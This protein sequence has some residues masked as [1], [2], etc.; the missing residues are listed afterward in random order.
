MMRI[1]RV[2]AGGQREQ[3]EAGEARDVPQGEGAGVERIDPGAGRPR[4]TR[5]A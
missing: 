2:A 5:A 1:T 3:I 4:L